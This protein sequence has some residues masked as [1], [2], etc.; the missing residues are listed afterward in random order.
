MAD[1]DDHLPLDDWQPMLESDELFLSS[2]KARQPPAKSEATRPMIVV[3]DSDDSE[4]VIIDNEKHVSSN[5]PSE[6]TPVSKAPTKERKR[7]SFTGIATVDSDGSSELTSLS[8]DDIDSDVV[9]VLPSKRKLVPQSQQPTPQVRRP[10]FIKTEV[11]SPNPSTPSAPSVPK[12]T[13][14]TKKRIE[15]IKQEEDETSSEDASEDEFV[16]EEDEEDED[17]EDV[18]YGSAK[19]KRSSSGRFVRNARPTVGSQCHDHT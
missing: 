3:Q 13:S 4:T 11:Q 15:P 10:V 17:Y 7:V 1:T 6:G 19:R 8:S 9:E 12:T 18:E 16:E 2:N 14:K 5:I